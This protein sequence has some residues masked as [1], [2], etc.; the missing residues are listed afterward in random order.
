MVPLVISSGAGAASRIAVGTGVMG[1]MIA[2]TAIGIF[3]IPL[4]YLLVRTRIAGRKPA[5]AAELSADGET[6]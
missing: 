3:I 4:L 2:A 5:P 1:G 6:A